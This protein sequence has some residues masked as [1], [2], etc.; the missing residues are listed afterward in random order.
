MILYLSVVNPQEIPSV[1]AVPILTHDPQFLSHLTQLD[2]EDGSSFPKRTARR[3][4]GVP[5]HAAKFDGGSY[6]KKVRARYIPLT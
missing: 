4:E 6:E 3:G 2:E 5:A 1:C